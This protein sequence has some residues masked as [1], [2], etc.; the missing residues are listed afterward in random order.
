MI[1][2]FWIKQVHVYV[3]KKQLFCDKIGERL[4]RITG[5]ISDPLKITLNRIA[6]DLLINSKNE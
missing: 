6:E 3:L 1:I 2:S 5:H 4:T